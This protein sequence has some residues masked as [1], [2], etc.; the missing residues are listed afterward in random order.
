MP[1]IQRNLKALEIA[2]SVLQAYEPESVGDMQ[3][4]Q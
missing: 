2:E 1:R 3:D 4:T